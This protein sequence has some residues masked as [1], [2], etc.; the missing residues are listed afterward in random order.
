[1]VRSPPPPPPPPP[2]PRGEGLC[3]TPDHQEPLTARAERV[4]AAPGRIFA[5]RTAAATTWIAALHAAPVRATSPSPTTATVP[6]P[7]GSHLETHRRRR[8]PIRLAASPSP[9]P[10]Y[11]DTTSRGVVT[12]V[13]TPAAPS[14][15]RSVCPSR[16]KEAG[17]ALRA[18]GR[19]EGVPVAVT[20]AYAE[21]R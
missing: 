8:R 11:L 9:P 13:A 20:M 17:I 6:D 2:P 4:A 14:V 15:C 18:Q 3:D 16:P 10:P 12:Q 19:G 1:M 5:F 21:K 7:P